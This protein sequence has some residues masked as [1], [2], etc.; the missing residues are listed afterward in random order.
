LRIALAQ[1]DDVTLLLMDLDLDEEARRD[2]P[3]LRDCRPET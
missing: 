3:F 2:M 1:E